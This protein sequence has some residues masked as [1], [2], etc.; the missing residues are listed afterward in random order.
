MATIQTTPAIQ[1]MIIFPD[2]FYW[3]LDNKEPAAFGSGSSWSNTNNTF[4]LNEWKILEGA[5]CVFLPTTGCKRGSDAF[6]NE[7]TYGYYWSTSY[8]NS[9]PHYLTFGG[10]SSSAF[11]TNQSS[12]SGATEYYYAIR[13][14]K[15]I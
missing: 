15:D 8:A 1:G 13:L 3:P 12:Y 14:V 9:V 2:V 4:T 11:S 10:N 7:N 5:G 6:N